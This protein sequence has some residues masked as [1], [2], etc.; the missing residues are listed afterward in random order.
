MDEKTL[1]DIIKTRNDLKR[2]FRSLK[3]GESDSNIFFEKTFSPITKPL[4]KIFSKSNSRIKLEKY[5][6]DDNEVQPIKLKTP[7]KKENLKKIETK[8]K[9]LYEKDGDDDVSSE[10][11]DKFFSEAEGSDTDSN[12]QEN[13]TLQNIENRNLDSGSSFTEN[14]STL[15]ENGK[16]DTLYGPHKN[17]DGSWGFGNT[18]LILNSDKIFIGTKSFLTTP[19]LYQLLFYKNPQHYNKDE[20]DI[21]ERI[22]LDTNAL[23][24]NFNS[25]EQIKGTKAVKYTNIIKKIV[26]KNKSIS[27][28]KNHEGLS[29]MNLKTEKTNYVF[30]DNPNELVSRLRLLI[31]SKNA[32]NNNH[33]NEII[34][35]IEELKEA[36]IIA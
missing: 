2:K 8:K 22:L 28:I 5:D 30:W 20:L 13:L 23:R 17:P 18:S 3:K 26:E 1:K 36:N 11:E 34:S 35:L 31:A 27:S 16:L 7:I 29:L 10:E 24:R 6:G 32:G 14:L 9:F 25:N 4:N 19:G 33:N 21:Y 15:E 12:D